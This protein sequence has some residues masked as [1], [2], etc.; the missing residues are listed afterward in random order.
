MKI[1]ACFALAIWSLCC[2]AICGMAWLTFNRIRPVQAIP[3]IQS[4]IAPLPAADLQPERV[5][6]SRIEPVER[7]TDFDGTRPTTAEE[8]ARWAQV[9]QYIKTATPAKRYPGRNPDCEHCK[10]GTMPP[11]GPRELISIGDP[12]PW[13]VLHGLTGFPGVPEAY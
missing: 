5:P 8:N 10:N 6:K 12:R 4:A 2:A 11:P 9:E 13:C 3:A 1:I 7:S